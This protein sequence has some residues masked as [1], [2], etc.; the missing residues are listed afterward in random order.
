MIRLQLEQTPEAA[1]AAV[2]YMDQ[3]W[4]EYKQSASLY[5]VA[6]WENQDLQNIKGLEAAQESQKAL[7]NLD[8]KNLSVSIFIESTCP[9]CDRYL[10]AVEKLQNA[11]RA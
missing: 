11:I 3:T 9:V 2:K 6:M 4:G 1:A 7:K 5:Q 10:G 8:T